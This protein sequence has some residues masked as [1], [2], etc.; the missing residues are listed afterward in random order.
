[1]KLKT[2]LDKFSI[3]RRDF[4]R[5]LEVDPIS[6]YRWETGRRFPRDHIIKIMEITKNKVTAN[7]FFETQES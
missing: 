6:L 5:Q 4:A 1:M 7:D 2:Y 3:D